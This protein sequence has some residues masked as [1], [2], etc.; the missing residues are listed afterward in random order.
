MRL[1]NIPPVG[2]VFYSNND[3][4]KFVILRYTHSGNYYL[5]QFDRCFAYIND[6][7]DIYKL[8]STHSYYFDMTTKYYNVNNNQ[9]VAIFEEDKSYGIGTKFKNIRDTFILV[10]VENKKFNLF[11]LKDG[12]RWNDGFVSDKET[13]TLEELKRLTGDKDWVVVE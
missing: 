1:K 8:L 12:N 10:R 9:P 5:Y 3:A 13:F 6:D 7:K 2:Q 4:K 11:C